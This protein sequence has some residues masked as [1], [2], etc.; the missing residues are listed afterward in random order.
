MLKLY[1]H[2]GMMTRQDVVSFQS[3]DSSALFASCDGSIAVTALLRLS[4]FAPSA[5]VSSLEVCDLKCS[6]ANCG[7]SDVCSCLGC[8]DN[9]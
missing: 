7:Y 6:F 3:L 5:V 2:S 8:I 9:A 1:K 4:V